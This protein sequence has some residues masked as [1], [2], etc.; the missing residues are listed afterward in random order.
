ME[1]YE[2]FSP[3]PL[4]G[5]CKRW[6]IGGSGNEREPLSVGGVPSNRL[7]THTQPPPA[8][9]TDSEREIAQFGLE[10]KTG[11]GRTKEN[12]PPCSRRSRYVFYV[13]P[14]RDCG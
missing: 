1:Y 8:A 3:T 11:F 7:A 14:R 6:E 5:L 12:S 13:G 4:A 10:H 2:G 9:V